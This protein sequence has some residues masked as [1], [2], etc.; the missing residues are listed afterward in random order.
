MKKLLIAVL[1]ICMSSTSAFAA[2]SGKNN[3]DPM[4]AEYESAIDTYS[5][6]GDV[7]WKEIFATAQK[8]QAIDPQNVIAFR[9]TVQFYR[10]QGAI[11]TAIDYCKATLKDSHTKE[12][13]I[14]ANY[15]LGY[16]HRHDW[17]VP[18]YA[19]KFTKK[20]LALV[21]NQYS[22]KE[23]DALINDPSE[24]TNTI[25]ELYKLKAELGI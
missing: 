22:D 1:L 11:K 18:F 9:A 20:A 16:M 7:D 14:E 2:K 13:G 12:I 25:K 10:Q 3:P 23:I 17:N 24:K 8:L 6:S 5:L 19:E 21:K 4:I 15:Q